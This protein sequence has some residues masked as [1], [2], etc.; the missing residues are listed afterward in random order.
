MTY[1]LNPISEDLY[2][3]IISTPEYYKFITKLIEQ[4]KPK[5]FMDAYWFII[6]ADQLQSLF[7]LQLTTEEFNQIQWE[8]IIQKLDDVPLEIKLA[9]TLFFS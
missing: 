3:Q 8:L 5:Y 6:P 1:N 2:N 9:R 4:Y 7:L